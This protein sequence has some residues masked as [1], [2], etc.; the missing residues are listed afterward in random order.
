MRFPP[1]TR[2]DNHY[3]VSSGHERWTRRP[4]GR[5]APLAVQGR[6]IRTVRLAG[7]LPG[8]LGKLIR[9]MLRQHDS[10]GVVREENTMDP[11]SK[12]LSALAEAP[13]EGPVVMLNLVR[14]RDRATDGDGT[15]RDAYL[16]YSSGFMPLLKR[17]GGTVLWGG[18]V[19]GTALGQGEKWDYAVLVQY[20]SRKDFVETIT[21][22]EYQGINSTRLA[23]LEDHLILAVSETY[24]KFIP[25]A[26]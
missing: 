12:Q 14:F 22:P 18:N 23:G 15:G 3:R 24:S 20:P 10:S 4:R 9:G 6:L 13:D 11:T 17:C 19:T 26:R 16:R 1:A 7:D 21:S 25:P 8:R 2:L 5:F